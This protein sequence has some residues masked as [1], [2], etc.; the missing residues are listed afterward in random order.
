MNEKTL[1]CLKCDYNLTGL[2]E[3]R[4]P[5]CGLAFDPEALAADMATWP[6]P[7]SWPVATFWLVLSPALVGACGFFTA[8]TGW[9]G[10]YKPIG[11]LWALGFLLSLSVPADCSGPFAAFLAMPPMTA[12]GRRSRL[13]WPV[14]FFSSIARYLCDPDRGTPNVR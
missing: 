5:E 3:N 13:Y 8:L 7:I 9:S 10:L 4:C 12:C 1:F 6:E 14:Y 11:I 2:T